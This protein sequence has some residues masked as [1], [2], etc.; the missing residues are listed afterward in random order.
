MVL[1][2]SVFQALSLGICLYQLPSSKFSRLQVSV[3]RWGPSAQIIGAWGGGVG[4]GFTFKPKHMLSISLH[5]P[6]KEAQ[7]V[8]TS[9]KASKWERQRR[10]KAAGEAGVVW[11]GVPGP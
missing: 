4:E 9:S 2:A 3:S 8:F 11:L 10:L 6:G 7:P 1:Q 5:L